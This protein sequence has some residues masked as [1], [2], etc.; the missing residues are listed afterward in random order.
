MIWIS[1]LLVFGCL[2][3][4]VAGL[5]S[6]GVP[7]GHEQL[8]HARIPWILLGLVWSG[9]GLGLAALARKRKLSNWLILGLEAPVV[10]F[11]SFYFIQGSFLPD[12]TIAL[13]VGQSFPSY[14]LLDQDG[15]IQG[16]DAGEPREPALYIFYRGDW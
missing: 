2:A 8:I 11:L 12:H 10:G 9:A 3:W 15:T 16:L 4:C 13:E 1:S 7:F 14:A 5:S 6:S